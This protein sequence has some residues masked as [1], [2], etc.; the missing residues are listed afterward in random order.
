MSRLAERVQRKPDSSAHGSLS[1]SHPLTLHVDVHSGLITHAHGSLGLV[2]T[3]QRTGRHLSLVPAP[4]EPP[5]AVMPCPEAS[6]GGVTAWLA[7]RSQ[8][9]SNKE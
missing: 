2:L 6:T 8:R 3:A 5:L 1:S 4:V 7:Q 9:R